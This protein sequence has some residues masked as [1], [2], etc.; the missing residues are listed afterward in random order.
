LQNR[1]PAGRAAKKNPGKDMVTGTASAKHYPGLFMKL[2]DAAS[3]RIFRDKRQNAASTEVASFPPAFSHVGPINTALQ[4]GSRRRATE[5]IVC[6]RRNANLSREFEGRSLE[7][8]PR[9]ASGGFCRFVGLPS[10]IGFAAATSPYCS[11]RLY[12]EVERIDH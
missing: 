7:R 2:A 1:H 8:Y 4:P 5:L 12:W 10:L 3:C 11:W 6:P 9:L